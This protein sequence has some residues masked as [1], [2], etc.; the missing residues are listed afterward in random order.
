MHLDRTAHNSG[1][2][3]VVAQQEAE[4]HRLSTSVNF[5]RLGDFIAGIKRF[6]YPSE[7]KMNRAVHSAGLVKDRR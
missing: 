7:T 1:S 2:F 5:S 6:R 4:E 3:S